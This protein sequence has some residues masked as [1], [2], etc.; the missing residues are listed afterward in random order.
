[1]DLQIF[2]KLEPTVAA[3]YGMTALFSG[4][5]AGIVMN[6]V[7]NADSR[8]PSNVLLSLV[9]FASLFTGFLTVRERA[10]VAALRLRAWKIL[11][12]FAL[13]AMLVALILGLLHGHFDQPRVQNPA[14]VPTPAATVAPTPTTSTATARA[15]PTGEPRRSATASPRRS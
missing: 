15:T 5:V 7:A 13:V 6:A 9:G 12:F 2:Y 1:V 14:R 3:L 8:L 11:L 4:V 10:T